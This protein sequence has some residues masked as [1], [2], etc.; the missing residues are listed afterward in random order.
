MTD[1]ICEI[2]LQRIDGTETTFGQFAGCVVLIVNVAS[3]CGLTAQYDQLQQLYENKRHLGLIVAGFPSNEFGGQEPGTDRQIADFCAIK[4]GVQFPM[5]AKLF[6][7]GEHQHPLYRLLTRE[8]PTAV[9]TLHG[10]LR[11]RLAARGF[12]QE[13]P[14][15]VLWNF[16]KFLVSRRG[17]VVGRFSP[18]TTT[19]DALLQD[20]LDRELSIV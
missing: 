9:Q 1:N 10:D 5:F 17:Q 4:F 3:A 11:T 7:K 2:S 14:C 20:A 15:D 19:S 6:V 8:Q 16:E 18:D 12:K 13:D